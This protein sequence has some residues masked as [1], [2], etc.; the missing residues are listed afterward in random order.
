MG[1]L[2]KARTILK[3]DAAVSA[4]LAVLL[5][6]SPTGILALL[7]LPA[8]ALWAPL[9]GVLTGAFAVALAAAPAAGPPAAR[10]VCGA[11]AV[12]NL[13][14]AAVIVAGLGSG[15]LGTGFL[16]AALLGLLA[17]VRLGFGALEAVY[18]GR[19]KGAAR[20]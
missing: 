12:A 1:G 14:S 18:W 8:P 5:L 6:L 2:P 17:V 10:V 7:D 9:A 20:G 16:G 15:T 4:L 3:A 11:A 19:L 13:G